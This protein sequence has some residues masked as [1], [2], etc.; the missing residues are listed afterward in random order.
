M[1][2]GDVLF[3]GPIDSRHADEVSDTGGMDHGIKSFWC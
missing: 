1:T 3:R 2:Q